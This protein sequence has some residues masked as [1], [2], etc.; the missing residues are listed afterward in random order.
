MEIFTGNKLFILSQE[1]ERTLVGGVSKLFHNFSLYRKAQYFY[2]TLASTL[3]SCYLKKKN[4]RKKNFYFC[5]SGGYKI[6]HSVSDRFT[7]LSSYLNKISS[8]FCT[9]K[10]NLKIWT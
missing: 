6:L 1:I 8:D 2:V 3:F 10:E 5:P 4:K 7:D 9:S